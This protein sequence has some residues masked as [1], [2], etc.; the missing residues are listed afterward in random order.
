MTTQQAGRD[1]RGTTRRPVLITIMALGVVVSLA[2]AS[3]V[4]AVFT[5]RATTGTNSASS[6][7]EA[8]SADIQIAEGVM[9]QGVMTCG[10]YE[11]DLTTGVITASDMV[12][13]G[14]FVYARVCLK[15]V[16][17]RTV[18]L[19]VTVL[20]LVDTDDACTGDEAALDTTCGGGQA[21]EL[22][23][24]LQVGVFDA[25]CAIGDGSFLG[26]TRIGELPNF[27]FSLPSIAAGEVGCVLFRM[28]DVAQ[29]DDVTKSQSDT[30][31]WRFAF[32]A[33]AV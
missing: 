12:P 1:R 6:R 29:G 23:P 19:T 20:D 14:G 30:S 24:H 21:G 7:A 25:D 2:G 9:D 27:P 10:T 8:R 18:D 11:E 32:D 13:L 28:E 4:F 16:G 33:T 31:T 5:D 3:G 26:Y 22:S 17:S 15:N